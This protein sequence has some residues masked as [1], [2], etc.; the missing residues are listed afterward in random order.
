L[1]VSSKRC[2]SHQ[3]TAVGISTQ[4]TAAVQNSTVGDE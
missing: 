3:E 4:K 2:R 1:K